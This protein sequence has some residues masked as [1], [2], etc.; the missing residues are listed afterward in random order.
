LVKKNITN[1]FTDEK[2][3]QNK[4]SLE[5]YRWIYSVGDSG[6]SSKYFSALGKMQTDSIRL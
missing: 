6:I 3:A 1:G 2:Y 5:I 4:I